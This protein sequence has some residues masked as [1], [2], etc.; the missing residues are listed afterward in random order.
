M[1]REIKF[2]SWDGIRMSHNYIMFNTS[3]GCLEVPTQGSFESTI[4]NPIQ[5]MQY[6]GLKDI[7]GKEIY[8][9]DVLRVGANLTCEILYIGANNNDYGDEINCAF[10]AIVYEH[11]RVIPIDGYFKDNCQVIG[12]IY[13]NP[14]LLKLKK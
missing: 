13:E 3:T 12:N 11:N 1:N 7:K 14:E 5:L 2:R 4:K 6:T 8:E 10:H 9:G